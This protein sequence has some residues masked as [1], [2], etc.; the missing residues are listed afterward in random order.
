M[1]AFMEPVEREVMAALVRRGHYPE[2]PDGFETA[3]ADARTLVD[4]WNKG[5]SEGFPGCQLVLA[6]LAMSCEVILLHDRLGLGAECRT[7]DLV[8]LDALLA[9]RCPPG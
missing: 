6:Q 5:A 4:A 2:T 8:E 3:V 1:T 9:R 7:G